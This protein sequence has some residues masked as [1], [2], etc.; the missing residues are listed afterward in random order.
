LELQNQSGS[1]IAGPSKTKPERLLS[2]DVLRGFDMFWIIGGTPLA[3]GIVH[4]SNNPRITSLDEHF[5]HADWHGFTGH[6]FIFPLFIFLSGVAMSFSLLDR[7]SYQGRKMVYLHVLRRVVLL[8]FLGLVYNNFFQFDFKNLRYPSVLGMIGLAYF[9]AAMVV[10]H[11][12]K[13]GQIAWVLAVLSGYYLALTFIPVPGFGPGVITPQGN[14]ASYIDR[15]VLPGRLL[16]TVHDPEGLLM[17]LPASVL[18]VL[19]VWAGQLLRLDRLGGY[20]KVFL[21]AAAGLILL[22]LGYR[23]D[24]WF[25][26]IKKLWTSSFILVASGWSF[27]LLAGFYL[28]IDV[29]RIRRIFFP[30]M[31]I[32]MNPITIYIVA[33]RLIDFNK[34]S[35]F[36][37]GGLASLAAEPYRPIITTLGVL[38]IEVLLLYFLYRKK[39]FLRV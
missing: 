13:K 10:L 17:T 3:A 23:W 24:Q 7:L 30:F 2:L 29:W 12:R 5:S 38:V 25:P 16:S 21:L 37:F 19:G 27:L 4:L 11:F 6:D 15:L 35:V 14:L 28:V 39:I 36:F 26:I 31:L 9:W 20:R 1:L 32:G 34:I 18:A 22:I 8:V 33:H